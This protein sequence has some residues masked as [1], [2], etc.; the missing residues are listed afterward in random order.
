MAR[1]RMTADERRQADDDVVAKHRVMAAGIR[2]DDY[3]SSTCA[4][5]TES[6]S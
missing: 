6:F 2:P 4:R 1:K 5:G 3:S